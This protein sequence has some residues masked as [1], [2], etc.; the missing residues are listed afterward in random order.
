MCPPF[1]ERPNFPN[2]PAL[3]ESRIDPRRCPSGAL[4]SSMLKS[5]SK[6]VSPT[7]KKKEAATPAKA[8]TSKP[9]KSS[10][11]SSA[12]L[13]AKMGPAAA[14]EKKKNSAEDEVN[15]LK[16]RLAKGHRLNDAELAQ[17]ELAAVARWNQLQ[18][19]EDEEYQRQ[20]E[21]EQQR[22]QQRE[23][24]LAQE[25]QEL[26]KAAAADRANLERAGK[27]V[28][29]ELKELRVMKEAAAADRE[30]L[31]A[32]M[33]QELSELREMREQQKREHRRAPS[34]EKE[35]RAAAM[36]YADDDEPQP[37]YGREYAPPTAQALPPPKKGKGAATFAPAI[38]EGYCSPR[39]SVCPGTS[40]AGP[41][42]AGSEDSGVPA[43]PPPSVPPSRGALLPPPPPPKKRAPAPKK[44]RVFEEL[45]AE[46]QLQKTAFEEY[47]EEKTRIAMR[48]TDGLP[49]RAM[50][51]EGWENL[52]NGSRLRYEKA[53]AAK[54][55]AAELERERAAKNPF[56]EVEYAAPGAPSEPRSEFTAKARVDFG[57]KSPP[58]KPVRRRLPEPPR[59]EGSAC[60]DLLTLVA[61]LLLLVV[62]GSWTASCAPPMTT[63]LSSLAPSGTSAEVLATAHGRRELAWAKF[64]PPSAPIAHSSSSS[65][66]SMDDSF[67]ARWAAVK[68]SM[69]SFE[70]EVELELSSSCTTPFA[71]EPGTTLLHLVAL[72]V[73]L[74]TLWTLLCHLGTRLCGGGSGIEY[75]PLV[76]TDLEAGEASPPAPVV[77]AAASFAPWT[78]LAAAELFIAGYGARWFAE[79]PP[80]RGTS[81]GAGLPTS[82]LENWPTDS[83]AVRL[84][85]SPSAA[86]S[87][88]LVA[89]ALLLLAA[90]RRAFQI[91]W[92]HREVAA[93]RRG[94]VIKPPAPKLAA[95]KA[96][97]LAPADKAAEKGRSQRGA[98][99]KP[100]AAKPGAAKPP[101]PSR[102]WL[103]WI[104]LIGTPAAAAAPSAAPPLTK[105][106][107]R[108]GA[109]VTPIPGKQFGPRARANLQANAKAMV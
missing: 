83:W 72:V 91:W 108:G 16:D 45:S 44:E 17:L 29:E 57:A 65:S 5:L 32:A 28:A 35:E 82:M 10:K 61:L 11:A 100:A 81:V 4:M 34:P 80:V 58:K 63:V 86:H 73:A 15:V 9:L 85:G 48:G 7:S 59:P 55:K 67:E 2:A 41:S 24:R 6:A 66:S 37:A 38:E 102:G 96:A 49:S 40:V 60:A 43:A 64:P 39:G 87:L 71:V 30:N 20:R 105:P 1:L 74:V 46:E 31:E 104:P 88:T 36:L 95:P 18:R 54:L 33:A 70:K 26:R 25:L 23:Q 89:A 47:A 78:S 98:A 94:D 90:G 92:W 103:S 93:A 8:S 56:V 101:P 84:L 53:A 97:A 50:L 42:S 99:V 14:P 19:E 51:H 3:F 68:L 22:E 77:A 21:L 79:P 62:L 52:P 69:K 109:A 107:G 76:E 106:N 13:D 27:A 75:A 12:V